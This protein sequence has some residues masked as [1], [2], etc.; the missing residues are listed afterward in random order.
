MM[1]PWSQTITMLH[2]WKN[3]SHVIR[4][5]SFQRKPLLHEAFDAALV[6]NVLERPSSTT[7]VIAWHDATRCSYGDQTWRT[8]RARKSGICAMSGR[9]IVPGDVVYRPS[10][11]SAP[12]NAHAMIL[13]SVLEDR[14]RLAA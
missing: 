12:C 6:V 13:A 8:S 3:E 1:D 2:A 9:S 4:P 10:R 7:A 14:Y 5:S 11:R